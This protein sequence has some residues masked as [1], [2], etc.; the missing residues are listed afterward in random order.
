[1]SEETARPLYIN[2][3]RKTSFP[4]GNCPTGDIPGGN[5]LT[6]DFPGG[7]FPTEDFPGQFSQKTGFHGEVLPNHRGTWTGC[8]GENS[9]PPG[10]PVNFWAATGL[11]P[12]GNFTHRAPTR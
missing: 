2:L 5:F 10:C 1:M 4:G 12:G 3:N 6:G 11:T 7:N 8:P 9:N